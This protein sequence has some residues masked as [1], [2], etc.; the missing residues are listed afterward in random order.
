MLAVDRLMPWERDEVIVARPSRGSLD[1][2]RAAGSGNP[3]PPAAA[4]ANTQPMPVGFVLAPVPVPRQPTAEAEAAFAAGEAAAAEENTDNDDDEPESD[5]LMASDGMLRLPPPTTTFADGE[6]SSQ[7]LI[8]EPSAGEDGLVDFSLVDISAHDDELSQLEVA[9]VNHLGETTDHSVSI[10][11][12]RL[13][14]GLGVVGKAVI[15][16]VF[17]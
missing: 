7:D 6:P 10:D 11:V 12:S 14:E 2:G 5:P 16:M 9:T 4:S 17:L 15:F 1:L 3:A 13:G 8:S